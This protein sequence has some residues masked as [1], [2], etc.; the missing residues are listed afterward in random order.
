MPSERQ[1]VVETVHVSKIFRD[2]WMRPKVKALD[3][4]DIQVH[5]GEIFGMLGPNGSGKSTLV[6]I[7]LGLLFPTSGRAAIFGRSPRNLAVKDRIGYMPEESYLY[8][9]LN[10]EETLN[11]YGRLFNLPRRERKHRVD[12]LLDMVGLQHQKKRPIVEYS[13][14]M[15]RRIGLAQALINDPDL[16]FLDE[17]TTGL[18]PIGTREIKDLIVELR[19]RGKTVVLCSHL[20][21]DVED[22]CDRVGILYGGKVRRLGDVDELLQVKARTQITADQLAPATVERVVAMIRDMEGGEKDVNVDSPRDR[23]EHFFLRVVEEARTAKVATAGTMAGTGANA[24]FSG[25]ERED[26]AELILSELMKSDEDRKPVKQEDVPEMTRT[27]VVLPATPDEKRQDEALI[28]SL[29]ADAKKPD[30]AKRDG[31]AEEAKDHMVLPAGEVAEAGP[32]TQ[33]ILG[34][35]LKPKPVAKPSDDEAAAEE[36]ER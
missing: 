36:S 15:A 4:V 25:I 6:K 1:V 18:D 16:V 32:S 26:K 3:K 11:F 7:L 28:S 20:L 34:D 29:T 30:A 22:V 9:Y 23:L 33:Q 12:L 13:K 8:R 24:F 17:P 5:Q 27:S 19:N 21:A 10:A 35:L 14:G 31:S 2:F